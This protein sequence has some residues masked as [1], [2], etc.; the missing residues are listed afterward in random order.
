MR[1]YLLDATEA[2]MLAC[3]RLMDEQNKIVVLTLIASL[4]DGGCQK[5]ANNVDLRLIKK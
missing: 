5:L 1:H 4:V 3:Y 2:E